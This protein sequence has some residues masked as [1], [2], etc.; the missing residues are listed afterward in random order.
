[1]PNSSTPIIWQQA[2]LSATS[3]W[4]LH[5]PALPTQAQYAPVYTVTTLDYNHDGKDD[6]LL[7][8]NINH[9]RIRFGKY[10]A[11]YGALLK[12]DGKW[13]LPIRYAAAIGFKL[14]GDVRGVLQLNDVLLFS[15]DKGRLKA[16]N[17]K[18]K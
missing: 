2:F 6:L 7:C 15:L 5:E 1:V 18:S 14:G 4:E 17:Y 16:Y 11:N 3:K 8:G 12:G 10:D 13:Q 9:S